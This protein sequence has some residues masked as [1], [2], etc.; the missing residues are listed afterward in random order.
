M[1]TATLLSAAIVFA[2]ACVV[3]CMLLC[4]VRLLIGPAAEDRVLA[5]DMILPAQ[6][7]PWQA[8][9]DQAVSAVERAFATVQPAVLRLASM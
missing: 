3:L 5:L 6:A 2:Q 8:A 4:T 1:T 7:G 9:C